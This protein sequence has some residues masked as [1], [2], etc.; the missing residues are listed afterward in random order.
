[1]KADTPYFVGIDIGTTSTKAMA[2]TL[3][4][5]TLALE[6]ASTPTLSPQAGF[7]EQEPEAL[8]QAVMEVLKKLARQLVAPP[9]AMGMSCAMHSLIAADE[10]GAPLTNALLWSDRR[11]E[12]QAERLKGTAEGRGFY[13]TCGTPIHP[14]S[15][16]CKIRWM[17]EESSGIFQRTARFLSIKDYVLQRLCGECRA[18]ISLASATGLMDIRELNWRPEA[19]A[20]AGIEEAQLPRLASPTHTLVVNT[21]KLPARFRGVPIA[22]GGSDGCLANLGSLALSP[23]EL[24]LTIGTSGALRATRSEPIIDEDKQIFNYRLDEEWFVCGGAINN[25]GITYQW[26]SE[27]LG[28]G[29]LPEQAASGL[30]AGAGGLLFLPYLLGERAP[31]WD[32]NA[33]GAFIGVRRHHGPAHFHRAVLEG[34]AFSLYHIFRGMPAAARQITANG[35]FTH[36]PLW[37]QIVADVFGLPVATDEQEEA[38]ARGAAFVAMKAAGAIKDYRELLP[39]KRTEKVFEPNMENHR[40]YQK[41]FKRYLSLVALKFR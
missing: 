20:Y 17:Q 39:L 40:A 33:S 24:V 18:D 27:L 22:L 3:E 8:L 32:A 13:K 28:P 23:E 1:M 16:L 19:L 35:G 9:A 11:S 26:L 29:R 5:K 6:R 41:E 25:G 4:G 7:Q 38:S 2:L 10:A 34:V 31:I 21:E 15:P 30:P 14:M 36:S 37:I 12:K